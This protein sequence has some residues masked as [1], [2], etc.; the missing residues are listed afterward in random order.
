MPIVSNYVNLH[1]LRAII[2]HKKVNLSIFIIICYTILNMSFLNFF[3]HLFYFWLNK[4]IIISVSNSCAYVKK[5]HSFSPLSYE[6]GVDVS[7]RRFC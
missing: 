3:R 4:S 7:R 5:V 1:E 2:T 6:S